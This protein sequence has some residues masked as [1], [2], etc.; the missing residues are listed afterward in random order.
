M[1]NLE[2]WEE[3]EHEDV[4]LGDELKIVWT[5]A[6]EGLKRKEVHTGSVR[7]LDSNRDFY[8]NGT[9][10]E[11]GE[12]Y[13]GTSTTIYRRKPTEFVFPTGTGAVIEGQGMKQPVKLI[14]LKGDRWYSLA[15]TGVYRE[16]LIRKTLTDL[17]VLS[18]GYQP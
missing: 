10:W 18:E 2:K 11:D 13:D 15:N 7:R 3:I 8:L 17:R 6:T 16:E 12:P 9:G 1:V 4:K 5:K 14:H